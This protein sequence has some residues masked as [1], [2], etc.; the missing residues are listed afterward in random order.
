MLVVN[1]STVS[2]NPLNPLGL[3]LR[4]HIWQSLDTAES[5]PEIESVILTG[6]GSN[7]SA[8]ADLTEFEVLLVSQQND[9]TGDGHFPLVELVRK[10]ENF[11]KPIV[12]AI[13]GNALGGGLE[14]ALSCHYRISN[15]KAKFGLP[16]VHVGVIPGAGGTQRLPRIVGVAKALEMILTGMP[17]GS[18]SASELGLVDHV[19]VPG[20]EDTLLDAATKWAEWA[21]LMPLAGRRAGYLPIKESPQTLEQIFAFTAAKLPLPAM[22]GEGVHAAMEAVK[23]CQL[24]I[25]EGSQVELQQF[26]TTL[27]GMQGRARRHAFF[28]VRKAQKPLGAPPAES[29]LL[30]KSYKGLNVA[31]I[32]AGLMGSGIAMVLLQVGFTVYLV[33]AYEE[34]LKKGDAFLQSTIQSYV[35]KGRMSQDRATQL[36][37]SLKTTQRMDDLSSCILVVEAVIE[38][39]KIKKDIFHKLDQITLP[40]CILLSNTSTLDIDEMAS[41]VSPSRR[42]RFAGWHFFSPAHIMKLVEIVQGKETS[43]NTTCLLQYL[44]KR[45]GKIGVVV[46]NCDG[47]VGNRLLI[48]YGAESTLLLE[49]GVATVS[50]VDQALVKFGMPMGPLQMGDLAGLDIGYNIRKQR[51]WINE[52]GTPSTKR[53][54]RYPEVADVLVAEYKRLGQKTGKGWYDYDKNAGGGRKP[55]HS[56]EVDELIR[57]Y[58]KVVP[59]RQFSQDEIVER[60]LFPLVNEGF[61]VLEEGIARQPSDIDVIY[62]YGYGWPIYRGGPMYWADHD[63]G[64]PRLLSRLQEFSRLFPSTDYYKPSTLLQTCVQKGITVEQY[65]AMNLHKQNGLTSKL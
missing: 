33:D 47:F 50:S 63:I 7:F 41:A 20:D 31:V 54:V 2:Q 18:S 59:R 1:F 57:R 9:K 44:T 52:D 62:I 51:G 5:D 32:G 58:V 30:Q 40:E 60:I 16:E 38:N 35:K 21:A 24:P 19:V 53:P 8:G 42:P 64:L 48:S 34:S 36:L 65:Y 27:T 26:F 12:A 55:I 61:K 14:V 46:G 39:I 17:I 3:D 25:G 4:K 13:S 28:A 45:I 43:W 37:H 10:I 29:A 56:K 11:S 6:G 15:A 23:A 22:G 49:E